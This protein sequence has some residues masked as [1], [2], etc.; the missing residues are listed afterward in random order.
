MSSL[1]DRLAEFAVDRFFSGRWITSRAAVWITKEPMS[2]LFLGR[3]RLSRQ[4]SWAGVQGAGMPR[5]NPVA[6]IWGV[7]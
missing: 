6:E 1:S 4:T 2:F 3:P 5:E 7:S